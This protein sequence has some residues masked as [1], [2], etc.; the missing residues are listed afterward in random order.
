M[1]ET[2][3]NLSRLAQE[4]ATLTRLMQASPVF[5]IEASE[6]ATPT[7]YTFI[8]LGQSLS[9]AKECPSQI[10]L[11]TEQRCEVELP[12]DFPESPPEIRWLT[13]IWHPNIAP[14]GIVRLADVGLP[15]M[16][17]VGLETVA[18]CLWDVARLAYVNPDRVVHQIA[19]EWLLDHP[20]TVLPVDP[21]SLREAYLVSNRNVVKYSRR[22][23]LPLA[24][25][26]SGILYLSAEQ[27]L[28]SAPDR[29]GVEQPAEFVFLEDN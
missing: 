13:S 6:G 27:Q 25:S 14:D 28:P 24:D 26:E 19:W 5:S 29:P 1:S 3:S 23:S 4:L 17:S 7:R 10:V 9:L 11:S 15:W 2:S 12:R 8:F 20:E 16:P 22:R 21:R 18:E